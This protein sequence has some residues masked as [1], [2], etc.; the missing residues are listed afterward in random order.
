MD[1]AVQSP[2]ATRKLRMVAPAPIPTPLKDI[3]PVNP[4][5]L[6]DA[7]LPNCPTDCPL[8]GIAPIVFG[9]G[10]DDFVAPRR[11]QNFPP[12]PQGDGEGLFQQDMLARFQ[13]S[14]GDGVVLVM[15]DD[16]IYGIHRT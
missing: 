13:A 9:D 8:V 3:Q 12:R 15:R 6:T 11:L 7:P 14:D 2:S 16:D 4:L 1:A 10:Q 5:R